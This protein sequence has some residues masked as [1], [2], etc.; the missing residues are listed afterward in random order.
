MKND[1]PRRGSFDR[2]Y[3]VLLAVGLLLG[4]AIGLFVGQA[5]AGAVIGLGAGGLAAVA[6]RLRG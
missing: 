3:G 4:L 2:G 6:L 5:S 1:P